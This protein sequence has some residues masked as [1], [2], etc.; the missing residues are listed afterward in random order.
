M[1]RI[2]VA[3]RE[4]PGASLQSRELSVVSGTGRDRAD[5]GWKRGSCL[6]A[7]RVSCMKSLVR[8]RHPDYELLCVFYKPRLPGPNGERKPGPCLSRPHLSP[9]GNRL[10]TRAGETLYLAWVSPSA[11]SSYALC[12]CGASSSAGTW[13]L[14]RSRCILGTRRRPSQPTPRPDVHSLP[15]N[16]T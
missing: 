13:N 8:S 12:R 11:P 3:W 6:P 10:P 5:D 2:C 16:Q 15:G 1:K 9:R 7:S 4:C 14:R